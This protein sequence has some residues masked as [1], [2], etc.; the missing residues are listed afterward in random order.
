MTTNYIRPTISYENV[1][2]LK[3]SSPSH[4]EDSNNDQTINLIPLVQDFNFSF[5]SRTEDILT[6]SEKFYAKRLNTYDVDV[7]LT[8]TAFETFENLFSGFFSGTEILDDFNKDCSFYFALSKEKYFSNFVGELDTINFGNA[9]ISDFNLSQSTKQF[10]TSKYTYTCSNVNADILSLERPYKY[11]TLEGGNLETAIPYYNT[12]ITQETIDGSTSI[13]INDVPSTP[14]GQTFALAANR[15]IF[16]SSPIHLHKNGK[17]SKVLPLSLSGKTF[18]YKNSRSEPHT[19][20]VLSLEDGANINLYQDGNGINGSSVSGL[21]LNS[22]ETGQFVQ[23][24]SNVFNFLHSN[25]NIIASKFG[26]SNND[27]IVLAP[28][29]EHVYRR[30]GTFESNIINTAPTVSTTHYVSHASGV[31]TSA[32]G[33]GAGTDSEGGIGLSKLTTFQSWGSK[34]RDYQI[35]AP[36]ANTTTKVYYFSGLNYNLL[37]SH[38]LNGTITNP[39]SVFRNGDGTSDDAGAGSFFNDMTLWKFESTNPVA[40]FVNDNSEDEDVLVGWNSTEVKNPAINLTGD[41]SQNLISRLPNIQSLLN[42]QS[43][44]QNEVY[45][46]HKTNISISGI[47]NSGLFLIDPD[48][49]ENFS[50]NL[51]FERK[52]IFQIGKRYPITRKFLD[53][54][55]GSLSM[56]IITS[57]FELTGTSSNLKDF[58]NLNDKY[59]LNLSFTSEGGSSNN[60]Q[61]SGARLNS[62]SQSISLTSRLNSDVSFNFNVYDFKRV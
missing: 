2:L 6:L 38:S 33:D 26:N 42:S 25:K 19:I 11:Y 29:E 34:L 49:V 37:E 16:G 10:L 1:S 18:G 7:N 52:K 46:S 62:N 45:P 36:Y 3:G 23:A 39:A 61:I 14:T 8:V 15:F 24:S 12:S 21:T 57:E 58:I 56:S 55:E 51:P 54:T 32:Q 59:V 44:L 40:V 28:A 53:N 17:D 22:G 35:V 27:Q 47:Q 31:V 30:R 5:N 43:N 60:F 13:Q 41:Q 4:S 9:F 48:I 50:L 20:F